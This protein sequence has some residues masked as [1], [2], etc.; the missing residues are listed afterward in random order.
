MRQNV[1]KHFYR[2]RRSFTV[3]EMTLVVSLLAMIGLAVNQSVVNGVKLWGA[4]RHLSVEE[5]VFIFL[6]R[7]GMDLRNAFQFSLIAFDGA[8]AELVFPT[9]VRTRQDRV[10]VGQQEAY[11][12]QIGRVEYVF[13]KAQGTVTRRQANY[14]QA[15]QS[16][17]GA[18]R[19][20]ASSVEGVSF[21]YLYA[22]DGELV[23]E[24]EGRGFLPL[25]V[26]VEVKFKEYNGDTREFARLLDIPL[27]GT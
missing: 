9:V 6:D 24:D 8:E 20:L 16:K 7:L 1:L 2:S 18:E 5:D 23:W 27:S 10:I 14:G 22:T 25:A 3:A 4:A 11:C 17:F 26:R 21:S 19:V 12:E 15:L 13:D